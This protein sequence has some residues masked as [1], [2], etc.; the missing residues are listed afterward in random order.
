MRHFS[1]RFMVNS[2]KI[3]MAPSIHHDRMCDGTA[4]GRKRKIFTFIPIKYAMESQRRG[5][6]HTHTLT[7]SNIHVRERQ[8][9]NA[10]PNKNPPK[11]PQTSIK[12]FERTL[13][14]VVTLCMPLVR[15]H[16]PHHPLIIRTNVITPHK[17]PLFRISRQSHRHNLSGILIS[18]S[19]PV[20]RIKLLGNG[21]SL[22]RIAFHALLN[23]FECKVWWN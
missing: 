11:S 22:W 19:L 6:T 18:H 14:T 3:A 17:K 8:V 1:E 20:A 13:S 2:R 4:A 5:H 15:P 23:E 9:A 12:H 10:M 21:W 16:L 7:Y